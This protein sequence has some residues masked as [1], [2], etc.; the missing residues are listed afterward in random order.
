LLFL[1]GFWVLLLGL[2]FVACYFEKR[3]REMRRDLYMDQNHEM[4][5]TLL[6]HRQETTEL[7]DRSIDRLARHRLVET[8]KKGKVTPRYRSIDDC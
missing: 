2:I 3:L 5:R 1:F 4:Q 7:L 6:Q 8:A